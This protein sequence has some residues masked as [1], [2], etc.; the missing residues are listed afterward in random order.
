MRLDPLNPLSAA[1]I[2]AAF[3]GR[4]SPTDANML[5]GPVL[6]NLADVQP[7]PIRWLWPSRLPLGKIALLAGDPG[8]GKSLLTIDLAARVSI[9][10]TWP[11]DPLGDGF[12]PGGVVMLSGEDDPADTIRPRLEAAGGNPSRVNM[13]RGVRRIEGGRETF[14]TF[15]DLAMLADAIDQTADARLVV[16]D[17]V[18]CYFSA[19]TDT[20]RTSDVRS[21]LAPLADLAAAKSVAVVLVSHLNKTMGGKAAYRITGSLALP[22]ACR[23]VW[24]VAKDQTDPARRVMVS[25]KA[26][27]AA[28]P[29]G[30]AFRTVGDPGGA[31]RVEWEPGRVDL[32][33]D[34]A[35]ADPVRGGGTD[36]GGEVEAAAQF[37]R[38]LLAG[39][40][41]PAKEIERQ[42]RAAG[43]S[44]ATLRRA[45]AA[46][47]V[48]VFRQGFG[49]GGGYFW[50]TDP[51]GDGAAEDRGLA[52]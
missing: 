22:A 31:G 50:T 49:A 12:T 48:R 35:L 24:L 16:I 37:L 23:A 41:L 46:A 2:D 40:S 29:G 3:A 14:F 33:A 21:V 42:A 15:D 4:P 28:D 39:Q 19:Q 5:P 17:P 25:G 43:F 47:G 20:H 30:L 44:V 26:N 10:R 51:P 34:D 45:K 9:G 38:T 11:D 7:M 6:L 8:L 13:L 27:L 32:S 18:T 52:P 36:D 1:T